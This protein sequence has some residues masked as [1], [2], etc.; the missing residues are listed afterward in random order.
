MIKANALTFEQVEPALHKWAKILS[1][2]RFEEWELINSAWLDGKVRFLPQSKIKYAS[3]R[4]RYDMVDYIR[5]ESSSRVKQRMLNRGLM[6]PSFYNFSYT[7]FMSPKEDGCA[8]ET[9]LEAENID[10]GQKD[11][12]RYLTS[13]PSLSRVEKLIMKLTYIENL[14]QEDIG[15]ACGLHA[16]RVSQIHINIMARLRNLDYSK[17]TG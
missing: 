12:V 16:S 2:N 7:T 1:N 8:F 14:S 13:H 17:I 4:I 3:R 10:I 6:V 11:V 9:T 15:K 5:K